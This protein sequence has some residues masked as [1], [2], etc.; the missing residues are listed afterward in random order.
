MII[1]RCVALVGRP[2]V[3]KSRLFNCLVRRRI[4]IVHDQP[5]VTRD[6]VSAE[7][8]NNYLLMDTGGLGMVTELTPKIISQA[9]EEQVDFA[10]QAASMVLF[11]VDG[12]EGVT[13]LDEAI[14]AKLRRVKKHVLVVANKIDHPGREGGLPEFY[15]LGFDAPLAVS[16]EH[17][18]NINSLRERIHAHLGPAPEPTAEETEAGEAERIS[19]CLAGRPNVG[20]SSLG[21]RL[22]KTNRLIVS[23]VPGTT[24]DTVQINLDY[25]APDGDTWRFKLSDTAGQRSKN[26]FD[27]AIEYFSSLR[28]Q[29]AVGDA[30]VVFLVLDAL[31]GVTRQDKKIAGEIVETGSGMVIVVN[32][33]DFAMKQFTRE[34]IEGF[35]NEHDFRKSFIEAIRKEL[36]FMPDCPI[37]FTSATRDVGLE[38]MLRAARQVRRNAQQDLPTAKINKTVQGL[39]EKQ[40]PRMKSGKRFKVY[41]CLQTARKP[42]TIRAYCNQPENI[43]DSYLRYLHVG[44]TQVFDLRGVPLKFQ[45][46][47]K[48]KQERK[49]PTERRR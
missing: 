24:R 30:D 29:E 34:P 43:D 22:L 1:D 26:K 46:I 5:G 27:N 37:V 7:V 3:G 8:D 39:F 49:R 36:F 6:I 12:H 4:A 23:E 33:W 25:P 35:E 11:V 21:N 47:G 41:Y 40:P 2:N 13:P 45:L 20:K 9:I 18:I 38:E 15:K 19:L 44:L 28:A 16:A 32:K 48:P 42:L 14:A 31:S 10:I 17:D